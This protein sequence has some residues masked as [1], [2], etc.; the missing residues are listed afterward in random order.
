[1]NDL[2]TLPPPLH[3]TGRPFQPAE[4]PRPAPLQQDPMARL[5][6]VVADNVGNWWGALVGGSK[7][8]PKRK[9]TVVRRIECGICCEN[10]LEAKL[11]CGHSYCK[12]CVVRLAA[13]KIKAKS[14][15][16]TC[17]DPDCKAAI[18]PAVLRKVL[19]AALYDQYLVIMMREEGTA[20][21]C[22]N[23]QCG[24]VMVVS[25]ERRLRR[26]ITCCECR[27]D[28]CGLCRG[29][30]HHGVS[31]ED[32]K[33]TGK[34][35]EV[36][37]RLAKLAEQCGWKR[38]PRCMNMTEKLDDDECDHMKCVSCL[39]EFCWDCSAD[40]FVIYA[41]GNHYHKPAC[42][43]YASFSGKEEADPK[44]CPACKELGSLCPRPL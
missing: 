44:R 24:A 20:A 42:K 30:V 43:Y 22:P 34:Q 29:Q 5:V 28:F 11:T 1:M 39:H 40:R 16:V 35:F 32:A 21:E 7:P 18:T 41:H 27:T 6:N 25:A 3:Q 10:G 9:I 23:D 15:K 12:T 36:S 26:H 8:Q 13:D 17:P 19:P 14:S 31:C 33:K 2:F 37:Q 38:C 4:R